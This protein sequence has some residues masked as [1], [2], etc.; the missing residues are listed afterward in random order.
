MSTVKCHVTK[1]SPI[2]FYARLAILKV[3]KAL[4]TRF[5]YHVVYRISFFC[6]YQTLQF[7]KTPEKYIKYTVEKVE[8]MLK[9]FF[10]V[11]A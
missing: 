11:S 2:G 6:R 10:D 1:Y 8:A 7:T 9:S 3:E 4:G 5:V